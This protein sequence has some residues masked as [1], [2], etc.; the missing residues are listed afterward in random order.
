M[1]LRS[2]IKIPPAAFSVNAG[3]T[4]VDR[5]V[6]SPAFRFVPSQYESEQ[7]R[8]VSLSERKS[9]VNKEHLALFP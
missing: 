2:L 1:I 4:S 6:P 3:C 5:N 9:Y 7:S 8:K